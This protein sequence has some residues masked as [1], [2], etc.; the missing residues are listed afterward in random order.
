MYNFSHI[1]TTRAISKFFQY[2]E[3]LV[4]PFV[5]VQ[6][7]INSFKI[8]LNFYGN[9][10]FAMWRIRE[11]GTELILIY[12]LQFPELEWE[13]GTSS[14]NWKFVTNI[15]CFKLLRI[16]ALA[17]CLKKYDVILIYVYLFRPI[18]NLSTPLVSYILMADIIPRLTINVGRAKLLRNFFILFYII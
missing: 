3:S 16:F 11:L 17:H 15:L 10:P 1:S 14:K 5:F 9:N 8:R 4:C 13:Y 7:R 6:W 2:V 12:L 18:V